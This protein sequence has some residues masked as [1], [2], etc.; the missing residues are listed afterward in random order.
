MD[1]VKANVCRLLDR[2]DHRDLIS[3]VTFSDEAQVLLPPT[4][5]SNKDYIE[6]K[7]NLISVSGST[8]MKK[9]LQT[10]IDL[11]WQGKQEAFSRYLILMTD[12]H[13]YGDEDACDDLAAKASEQGIVISALGFGSAWNDHF[14]E[15]IT[16]KTGGST[17]YVS[18]KEDLYRYLDRLFKTMDITYA[19]KMILH[20]EK[21]PKAELRIFIQLEPS[22]VQHDIKNIEI[23]LGDLLYGK[24]SIFLLEYLIHPLIKKDKD[25]ELFVGNVRMELS[26]DETTKARLYPKLIVPVMEDLAVGR[27]PDEIVRAISRLTMFFMQERS[28]EDVKIGNYTKAT[29]RLNFLGAKLVTEGETLLANKTFLESETIQKT[30][31]FSIDGEKELKYGT[32]MLLAPKNP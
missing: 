1:M 2:L 12:G 10:G 31:Q 28:R 22:I 4:H 27:P 7:I 15:R 24:K 6:S 5:L 30:H 13:T 8:E 17:L 23:N 9:G 14:L 21:K 11:L 16:S 19:R 25:V 32:K 20:L 26:R 18:S 3:I 29:R